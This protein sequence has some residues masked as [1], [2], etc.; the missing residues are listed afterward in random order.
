MNIK[1]AFLTVVTV[2]VVLVASYVGVIFYLMSGYC[3]GNP[4]SSVNIQISYGDGDYYDGMVYDENFSIAFLST[5]ITDYSYIEQ[6]KKFTYENVLINDTTYINFTSNTSF[7]ISYALPLINVTSAMEALNN[8]LV[9][10]NSIRSVDVILE[11]TIGAAPCSCF[12]IYRSDHED[13][14]FLFFYEE[15][16]CVD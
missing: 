8:S 11:I 12:S 9:I 10:I 6:S 1:T 5:P 15:I 3:D 4:S 7:R 14:D 2:I 16:L 13:N